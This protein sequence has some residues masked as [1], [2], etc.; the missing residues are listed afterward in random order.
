VLSQIAVAPINHVLRGESWALRR[1]QPYAG[2]TARFEVLPFW[3]EFT[4]RDNGEVAPAVPGAAADTT[5]RLTPP[6]ALRI[7]AGD[8]SAY[9]QVDVSGDAEFAQAVE[10]VV[11]NARWDVE[12]D[13]SRLVGDAAAHRLARTGSSLAE[14]PVRLAQNVAR[15]LSDYWV[16][17]RP[18]IA[19]RSDVQGFVYDVD[20]LRDDVERL[21]QRISRLEAR[22][23]PHAA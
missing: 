16:E 8:Q 12:E 18:L 11:R 14:L 19:R 2:R 23:P 13:L 7:L 6:A 4:V 22:E 15:N 1:L 9:E 17:E 5:F 21:A 3:L 20:T 10:F